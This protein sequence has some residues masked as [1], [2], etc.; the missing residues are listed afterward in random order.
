MIALNTPL[1]YFV[2]IE[3]VAYQKQASDLYKG[4]QIAIERLRQ[5]NK[6]A[7]KIWDRINYI[8]SNRVRVCEILLVKFLASPPMLL[9][10]CFCCPFLYCSLCYFFRQLLFCQSCN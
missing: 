10:L 7:N 8:M 6:N 5:I 2:E 9:L 1:L 4:K 3:V